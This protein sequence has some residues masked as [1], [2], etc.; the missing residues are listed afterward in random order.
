MCLDAGMLRGVKWKCPEYV[1]TLGNNFVRI[2]RQTL[3]RE[4]SVF[5]KIGSVGQD[6]SSVFKNFA[7]LVLE[8][9][10]IINLILSADSSSSDA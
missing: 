1:R 10:I 5:S 4:F 3:D 2:C 8:C 6:L 7:V 9:S